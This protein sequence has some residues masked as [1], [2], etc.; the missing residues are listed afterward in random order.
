MKK[1]L[2][3]RFLTFLLTFV[4]IAGL[5]T[6]AFASMDSPDSQT[7][8]TTADAQEDDSWR[9]GIVLHTDFLDFSN[10]GQT[11]KLSIE[12]I[13]PANA[14]VNWST[15]D[16]AVATVSSSGIVTAVGRGECI[17]TASLKTDPNISAV[18]YV[19]V[20]RYAITYHYKNGFSSQTKYYDGYSEVS[21]KSPKRKGYTFVGW[22]TDSTY[23][24]RIK[25]IC[26]DNVKNYNLY[27]KWKKTTKPGKPSIKLASTTPGKLKVSVSKKASG[28][29][30]YQI[31]I[32]KNKALKK[33]NKIISISGTSKTLSGLTAG[34]KYYIK[35]RAYTSDSAGYKLYGA[36]SSIKSVTVKKAST[37]SNS[38]RTVYITRTG[39]KYHRNGCRY[40]RQSK[41]PISKSAAQRQGYSP[42]KV[43]RP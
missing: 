34:A 32:S 1:T 27:A 31:V 18:C 12:D 40:L 29:T 5:P 21:L 37:K 8:D 24:N 2:Q 15:D 22:Y 9:Y 38:G 26:E 4:L 20:N 14:Q 25:K 17:I 28:A 11:S 10:P 41:I 30:G 42:C 3:L 6:V 16:P 35:I 43:C 13:Y 36:Y 39:S 19:Y 23:K 33:G 7:D